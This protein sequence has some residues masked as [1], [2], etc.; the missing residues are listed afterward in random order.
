MFGLRCWCCSRSLLL[1]I[2]KPRWAS[3]QFFRERPTFDGDKR[4]RKIDPPP[5]PPSS[6]LLLL[7]SIFRERP[8]FDAGERP[9]ITEYPPPYFY[10][11]KEC[12]KRRSTGACVFSCCF[13]RYRMGVLF[14]APLLM[15]SALAL[16]LAFSF[17]FR[18]VVRPAV[19]C[20]RSRLVVVG[21]VPFCC[22]L[23]QRQIQ[24]G[25]NILK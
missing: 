13:L 18:A 3:T 6:F 11:I 17:G 1:A 9:R 22:L 12:K 8:T 25:H 7:L 21:V 10:L 23:D 5:S 16:A 4:P 24:T 2:G 20:G 14:C 19:L 15:P